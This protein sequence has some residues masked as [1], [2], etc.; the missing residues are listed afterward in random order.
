VNYETGVLLA[1]EDFRDEQTYHRTRLAT[2]LKYVVGF[3]TLAGLRVTPPAVGDAELELSVEP[4]IAIDR[5]GRLIELQAAQ[6][7]RLARWFAA[8]TTPD[9]NAAIQHSPRVTVPVA[10]VADVF[11]SAATCPRGKTPSFQT[12]T[13]DA[14]D[15]VI[16]AR[17]AENASLELVRRTEGPPNPI[18]TP[19][20]HW[21]AP[22][23]SHDTL[24]QAV[25]ASWEPT[26]TSVDGTL[27][28]L[29]EHVDGHDPSSLFLARVAIPVVEAVAP[30]TRP[31]IDPTTAVSVD[32]SA[33][34]F[35][36][37]PGKWIGR[38]FSVVPLVQ[39]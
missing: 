14:L 6:C 3:G 38:A 25:L 34:P 2:V 15:A 31:T 21:P 8:Q 9:L 17:L 24:L 28:P 33:R 35:V 19:A 20:N 22:N 1:A 29:Q 11:L 26:P 5:Y 32:N 37:V 23:T 36:A 39:P 4:G 10:V 13:F 16:P 7:M 18:P 12:G 30:A 27:D